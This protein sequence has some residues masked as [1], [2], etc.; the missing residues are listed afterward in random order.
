MAFWLKTA[1]K[2]RQQLPKNA[3]NEDWLIYLRPVAPNKIQ[4]VV[5]EDDKALKNGKFKFEPVTVELN[6]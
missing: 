5:A 4:Y 1:K 2:S 3:V 6:Y